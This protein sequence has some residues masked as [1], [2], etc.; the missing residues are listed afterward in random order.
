M[1]PITLRVLILRFHEVELNF[2]IH[3]T[4][5][6]RLKFESTGLV[7]VAVSRLKLML[8][9]YMQ[10]SQI[11]A[12]HATWCRMHPLFGKNQSLSFARESPT[13]IDVIKRHFLELVTTR[14][15]RKE[16]AETI[17]RE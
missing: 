6:K 16:K 2:A 11:Y 7:D 9:K 12:K 14:E 13:V 4:K 10:Y 1:I 17:K 5:D 8:C 3:A 15:G